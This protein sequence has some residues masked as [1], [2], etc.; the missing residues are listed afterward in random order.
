MTESTITVYSNP[1]DIPAPVVAQTVPATT[2]SPLTLLTEVDVVTQI[3][4][5]VVNGDAPMSDSIPLR[6]GG[7][8]YTFRPTEAFWNHR[9]TR[10][11]LAAAA[12]LAS[13]PEPDEPQAEEP[14]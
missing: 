6:L 4:S 9:A 11:A 7:A 8:A 5:T 10:R 12:A 2:I 1:D 14:P 13:Q 3:A